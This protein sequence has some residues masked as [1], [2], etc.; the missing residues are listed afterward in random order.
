MHNN[1]Y[2]SR[3]PKTT[4]NLERREY[5]VISVAVTGHSGKFVMIAC[6]NTQKEYHV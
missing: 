2:E 6:R 1:I 5:T 4:Y 3:K